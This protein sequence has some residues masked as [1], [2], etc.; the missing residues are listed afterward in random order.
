MNIENTVYTFVDVN[1]RLKV[2]NRKNGE[3]AFLDNLE[4]VDLFLSQTQ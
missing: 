4:E 1:C 2:M 3:E